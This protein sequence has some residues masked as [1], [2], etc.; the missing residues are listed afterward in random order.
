[1]LPKEW[2]VLLAESGISKQDQ[3]ANPQAVI[4]II[5][6]YSETSGGTDLRDQLGDGASPRPREHYAEQKVSPWIR[7][8]ED[9]APGSRETSTY[10]E[11]ILGGY[12][13]SGETPT[14]GVACSTSK[15]C[16]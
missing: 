10:L 1:G 16:T 12:E 3:Q 7:G 2:Q 4:D 13:G 11:R 15:A 9:E 6:F 5:G 14:C 8:R